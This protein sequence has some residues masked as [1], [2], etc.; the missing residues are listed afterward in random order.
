MYLEVMWGFDTLSVPFET[1]PLSHITDP[2]GGRQWKN[3]LIGM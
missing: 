1:P 2:W 3:T